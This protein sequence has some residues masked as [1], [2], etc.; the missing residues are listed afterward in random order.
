ML[1]QT[2][3]ESRRSTIRHVQRI[4]SKDGGAI[5]YVPQICTPEKQL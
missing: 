2:W 3:R 5:F 1:H 4:E